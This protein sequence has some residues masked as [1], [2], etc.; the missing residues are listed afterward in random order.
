MPPGNMMGML[1]HFLFAYLSGI[2]VLTVLVHAQGQSGF[3]SI[4]CGTP[5][6]S[7]YIDKTTGLNYVSDSGFIENY[8]GLS[9]TISVEY[10]TSNSLEQQLWELRS[11]PQGDKNC[12]TLKPADGKGNKYLIRARFLYGNYDG[13]VTVPGFDL[14]L[15]ANKWGTVKL[16]NASSVTTMEIIHIPISDY[17]FVC[18]V[19]TGH[20]TPFI[21]ALELRPM[22]NSTYTPTRAAVLYRRLDVGSGSKTPIRYKDDIYDRIWQPFNFAGRKVLNTSLTIDLNIISHYQIPSIVMATA[23]A[24][25]NESS[26]TFSFYMRPDSPTLEY[27]VYM[28][29]AEVEKLHANQSREFFIYQN[30]EFWND[31]DIIPVSPGYLTSTTVSSNLPVSG[32]KISYD[33]VQTN[34]STHPPILNALEVYI[35]QN[36]SEP[37]S[38]EK[39][40]GVMLNIKSKYGV[41]K[42]W[43]GDPCA[44]K[45]YMWDGLNCN[46]SGQDPVRIISLNLSSSGLTGEIASYMSDLTMLQFLDLSNNSL[47]GSVPDFLSKLQFLKV[48]K[49]QGNNLTGSVPV[50]LIERSTS[51]SLSL[52]VDGNSNLCT[53]LSCQKKKRKYT[54]PVIASVSSLLVLLVAFLIGW[55]VIKRRKRDTVRKPDKPKTM[56]KTGSA[57]EPK[58]HQFTYSEIIS[59]TNNF[60]KKV[61]IGGFGTVYHG[62]L[63][64][65][66]VAVKMLSKSSAQGYK[67][68]QAEVKILMRVHHRNLTNLIGYCIEGDYMGLIYEYMANGNLGRHLS[69]KNAYTLSWED[70]M[71]IAVDAAQGLEYLHHGCKPSIIHRDVK[72]TNILLN[73]KFQA[74]LADFG[75][76]R[77]FP[78]E[79]GTHVSTVVAGTLGYL[80][81]EYFKS[82]WLNEKSDVYS[83][84]VVLLE[85]ITS[86][87]VLEKINDHK[88]I[89]ISQWVEH[90]LENGQIKSIVDPR[91]R[92][93]F[94]V[95]SA[96]KAVEIATACV[97]LIS[98]ERPTM[99]QV[100]MELKE[101][102]ALEI[103]PRKDGRSTKDS[104]RKMTLNVDTSIN[105]LPR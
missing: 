30:G 25:G 14:Y 36:F 37:Q 32:D 101:C 54:I 28:H 95:N 85:I 59:I 15:G 80:D 23:M 26:T 22:K 76:S 43:Q 73:E 75:L 33:L 79:G 2:L 29:F 17:I 52:S 89:H 7:T 98:N 16:D 83:F 90:I 93:D 102:L 47:T 72:T 41:K 10:S 100:V 48:L 104:V 51:G 18:L 50:D 67:E 91:L 45:T 81:P 68:F 82:N 40:V 34:T 88:S 46:F 70:R 44:P 65:T 13:K 8:I 21:S 105:P 9:S 27:Y 94:Q 57:L 3:I 62:Y 20:G 92:G 61:G 55:R 12:Y 39:D 56:R 96:W 69:D 38:D 35:V 6:N 97:S 11:F 64:D 87:P 4:D 24:P 53:S 42:N 86:R 60:E 74:K 58:N 77:A 19:N 99:N 78:M 103:A 66:Q 49:L 1:K 5:E 31:N 84:G 71:Q 63:N